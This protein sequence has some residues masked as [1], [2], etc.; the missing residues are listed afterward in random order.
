MLLDVLQHLEGAGVE[1]AGDAERPGVRCGRSCALGS[2]VGHWGML[3]CAAARSATQRSRFE[4]ASGADPRGHG[5]DGPRRRAPVSD[6]LFQFHE[7]LLAVA[8]RIENVRPVPAGVCNSHC[9]GRRRWGGFGRLRRG[10][11]IVGPRLHERPA[12]LEQVAAAVGGLD[13]VAV[14]MRQGEFADVAGRLGTLR[15]PV[16]EAGAEAVRHGVD[17]DLVQELPPCPFWLGMR[18]VALGNTR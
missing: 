14:D 12:A 11:E 15:G 7:D 17:A 8:M 1:V 2:L 10:G 5:G 18:P 4:G 9:N 6:G 13:A 16:P 3:S